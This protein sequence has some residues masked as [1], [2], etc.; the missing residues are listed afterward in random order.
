MKTRRHPFLDDYRLAEEYITLEEELENF[1]FY[2]RYLEP[3]ILESRS[4]KSESIENASSDSLSSSDPYFL[5]EAGNSLK[6]SIEKF[7]DVK[8][9]EFLVLFFH[10]NLNVGGS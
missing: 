5:D 7:I 10:T 2:K 3:I 9:F 4:S 8:I 1:V 6:K